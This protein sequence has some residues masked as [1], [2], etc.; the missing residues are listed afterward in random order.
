MTGATTS[1]TSTADGVRERRWRMLI[2][3]ELVDA[4]SRYPV[5]NPTDEQLL[6][7]A[8]D[9]TH[10][11]PQDGDLAPGA[12]FTPARGAAVH[13]GPHP[14]F[15]TD[16]QPQMAAFL[17]QASGPATVT[18]TVYAARTTHVPELARLGL[19]IGVA[20]SKQEIAGRQRAHG[21]NATVRDIRCG[22]ALIVAAAATDDSVHL[23]DPAGHL[24]RGYGHLAGKLTRL[25]ID[26]DDLNP[27]MC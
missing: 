27:G 14:G 23:Y 19:D 5:H 20:E 16:A 7:E 1:P 22:A 13:T 6:A 21:G 8:P 12:G 17:P 11:I 26:L 18:E 24:T 9:G 15:P 4:A 3:G 2:G 10:A 25:G